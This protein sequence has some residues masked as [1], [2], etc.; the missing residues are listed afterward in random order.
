M[1]T[2]TPSRLRSRARL[3]RCGLV[4]IFRIRSVVEQILNGDDWNFAVKP[5]LG[6]ACGLLVR[7]STKA[8]R[9]ESPLFF[10][11]NAKHKVTLLLTPSPQCTRTLPPFCSQ[12]SI[13][14]QVCMT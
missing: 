12:L 7:T 8:S 4:K 6:F 3:R 14:A 10:T 13:D 2:V 11:K 5:L 1:A 9:S